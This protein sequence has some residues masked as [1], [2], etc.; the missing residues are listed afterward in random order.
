MKR[1][2]VLFLFD[3]CVSKVRMIS[4]V[5]SLRKFV[6]IQARC[7][8]EVCGQHRQILWSRLLAVLYPAAPEPTQFTWIRQP[9]PEHPKKWPP[10]N[11]LR[12]FATSA[13]L[14]AVGSANMKGSLF[15]IK[16]PHRVE[17]SCKVCDAKSSD[18]DPVQPA[19]Y[20]HWGCYE[21]GGVIPRASVCS[22]C[23]LQT[24]SWFRN[25]YSTVCC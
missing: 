8:L 4:R 10:Y 5:L 25:K 13:A 23:S 3:Q 18:V 22:Y 19:E 7:A 9:A 17:R 15:C 12:I 11:M 16:A 6:P 20:Y 1:K 24:V 2:L 21:P 14:L